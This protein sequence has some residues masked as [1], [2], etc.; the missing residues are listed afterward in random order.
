MSALLSLGMSA[1]LA[2]SLDRGSELPLPQVDQGEGFGAFEEALGRRVTAADVP[3]NSQ[4]I[5][6][7]CDRV[8][9]RCDDCARTIRLAQETMTGLV[10]AERHEQH[11]V[12]EHHSNAR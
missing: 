8:L 4:E 2:V 3:P 11:G 10:A 5:L 12:M 9:A 6:A 1:D 7:I